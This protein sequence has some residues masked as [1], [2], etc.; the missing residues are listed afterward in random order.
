VEQALALEPD[1]ILLD[2]VMPRKTSYS[3]SSPKIDTRGRSVSR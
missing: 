1:V 2:L 3:L